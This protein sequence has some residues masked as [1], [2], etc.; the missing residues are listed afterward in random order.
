MITDSDLTTAYERNMI[1][2]NLHERLKK[3]TLI[4]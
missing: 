2:Y 3:K 4:N 1:L